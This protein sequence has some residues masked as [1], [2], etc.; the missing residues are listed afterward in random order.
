M[1]AKKKTEAEREGEEERESERHTCM[2]ISELPLRLENNVLTN[3]SCATA[4]SSRH[5]RLRLP[6]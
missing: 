6:R 4:Y 1:R 3:V 5:V 2:A